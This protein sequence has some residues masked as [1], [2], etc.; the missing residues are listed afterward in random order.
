[1]GSYLEFFAF[2]EEPN[3]SNLKKLDWLTAWRL[4]KQVDADAW[5][6]E[7]PKEDDTIS[8][9]EEL[10]FGELPIV[11]GV[12]GISD[13][14]IKRAK[15]EAGNRVVFDERWF[16]LGAAL[17][18]SLDQSVI[19]MAGDD[20]GCDSFCVFDRGVLIGA[21]LQVDW[22][23]AMV[24]KKDGTILIERLYPPGTDPDLAE[25]RMLHQIASEGAAAYFGAED[26]L[27]SSDPY[28]FDQ[29]NYKLLVKQGEAPAKKIWLSDTLFNR[30]GY[31]PRLREFV[32]EI[33]PYI[34]AA[35]APSLINAENEQRFEVGANL[36]QLVVYFGRCHQ[37]PKLTQA[38]LVRA[39]K[40]FLSDLSGYTRAL[41]PKP[42]FRKGGSQLPEFQRSLA[43]RWQSIKL[44]AQIFG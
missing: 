27:V 28:E 18:A 40:E 6:L 15:P 3:L 5:Y 16:Q 22:D 37:R 17:S 23:K 41:R 29:R 4:F 10:R 13:G 24:V 21:K 20:I 32:R 19:H 2:R 11:P 34:D 44:Q 26:W 35:V 12:K 43:R 31:E 8:F 39:I 30:F 1:M 42:E 14:I 33:G 7:G 9:C 25:S 38:L 36:T